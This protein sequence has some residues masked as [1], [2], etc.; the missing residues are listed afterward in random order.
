MVPFQIDFV[1]DGGLGIIIKNLSCNIYKTIAV[2]TKMFTAQSS[3][4]EAKNET[5][6]PPEIMCVVGTQLHT[7]VI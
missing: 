4:N 3:T 2:Q 1:V 7:V 5:D 6:V